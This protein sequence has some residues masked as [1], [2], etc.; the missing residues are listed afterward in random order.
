M[1]T[2]RPH[3]FTMRKLLIIGGTLAGLCVA[4]IVVA[5]FYLG[6]VVTTGVNRLAPGIMQT[7]VVLSSA[8]ISPFS[9]SG[10]LR[11]LVVGNPKGWSDADLCS[12]RSIHVN[13]DPRSIFGDHV[14]VRDID[15]DAP[16]FSYETRLVSSNVA[17]LS[18]SI[19]RASGSPAPAATAKSGKP[20]RLEVKHIR[21]RNGAVRLG[22]GTA[23]IRLPLPTIELTDLGT[24]EGG[25][26]PDRIASA[27]IRRVA[28]DIVSATTHA[29]GAVASTTGAAAA[30]GAKKAGSA[31]KGLFGKRK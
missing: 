17:D 8:T 21:L 6:S 3:Y 20:V 27:V 9:G 10:T 29:A 31:I 13:V 24:R 4:A 7:R 11:Q 2:E 30:E 23:A 12:L 22:V 18:T 19:S 1:A 28:E 16:E 5:S 14:V 26:T 15:I 25:V